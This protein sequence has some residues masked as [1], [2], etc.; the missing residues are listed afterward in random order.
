MIIVPTSD[1]SAGSRLAQGKKK[2]QLMVSIRPQLDTG[3]LMKK[4]IS[5]LTNMELKRTHKKKTK[6][7]Y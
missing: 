3:L 7:E 4:W 6:I 2:S 5:W 1:T